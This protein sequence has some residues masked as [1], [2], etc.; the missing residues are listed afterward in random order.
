MENIKRIPVGENILLKQI[1]LED[2][3]DIFN[4][5]NNQRQ[6]LRKWL[7]FVDLTNEIKDTQSFITSM[8]DVPEENKEYVFV[9]HCKGSF[10][11]LIGFKDTDRLNKKTEIGYW[12]SEIYQKKGIITES[13]K[14]LLHFAFDE[15]AI[16][17]VQIKCA[18]GNT[19]SKNIPK[20]LGFKFEGIE[21]DGELL[22]D[23]QF[24]DIEVYSLIKKDICH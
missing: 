19:Q 14:V 12:L 6:Y 1:E 13:V 10:V 24:T 18:V 22:V 5:I 20:R 17:R 16:N 23:N 11:G 7:P 9:I 4:T 3:T 8:L 2:A 21:R 15:L